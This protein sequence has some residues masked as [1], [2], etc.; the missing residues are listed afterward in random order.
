MSFRTIV[1]LGG[2]TAYLLFPVKLC[3]NCI[4]T[5][6]TFS[7]QDKKRKPKVCLSGQYITSVNTIQTK[8]TSERLKYVYLGNI[9]SVNT[10]QI[11][12]TSGS[13]KYVHLGN[14]TSVNTIQIKTTS[15]SL[16]YVYLDNI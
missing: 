8:T 14:I 12:T 7:K 1:P 13:L 6:Y 15:G 11:K 10:I 3:K 2:L 4:V 9:T 5:E 16:K